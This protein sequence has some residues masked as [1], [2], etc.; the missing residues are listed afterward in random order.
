MISGWLGYKDTQHPERRVRNVRHVWISH[1]L[2]GFNGLKS[3]KSVQSVAY[4]FL[5]IRGFD[6]SRRL[7][8]PAI[9][10]A[11]RPGR[12]DLIQRHAFFDHVLNAVANDRDHVAIFDNIGFVGIRPWPGMTIVPPSCQSFGI[13]RSMMRFSPSR[14][15]LKLPPFSDR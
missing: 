13:V 5:P 14:T 15:P 4:S 8:I 6:Q 11:S 2:N 7:A 3:V 10:I 9:V 12:F 1:G